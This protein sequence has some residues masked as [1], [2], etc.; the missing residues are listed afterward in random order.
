[1]HRSVTIYTCD[2]CGHETTLRLSDQPSGWVTFRRYSPV[3]AIDSN[4]S[5]ELCHSC[6]G[7]VFE[8]LRMKP[9]DEEELRGDH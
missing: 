4:K 7:E 8:F 5:W 2:R 9:V 1:M 6:H 3:L